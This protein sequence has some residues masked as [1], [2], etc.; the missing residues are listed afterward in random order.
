MLRTITTNTALS[1]SL[2]LTTPFTQNSLN[3]IRSALTGSSVRHVID[4]NE[5]HAAVLIPFCN[6][7]G[8]PGV[9]LELRGKLRTHSGEV[10]CVF[11]LDCAV[12]ARVGVSCPPTFKLSGWAC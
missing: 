12:K 1:S 11:G 4:A 3:K 7:D 8:Q 5:K 9:L 2:A 6:V 10:R